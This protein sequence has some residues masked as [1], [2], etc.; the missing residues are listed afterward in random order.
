MEVESDRFAG[1]IIWQIGLRGVISDDVNR[2]TV[3]SIFVCFVERCIFDTVNHEIRI[4]CFEPAVLATVDVFVV[5]VGS[6]WNGLDGIGGIGGNRAVGGL[7]AANDAVVEVDVAAVDTVNAASNHWGSVGAIRNGTIVGAEPGWVIVVVMFDAVGATSNSAAG[8]IVDA[9]FYACTGLASRGGDDIATA[10]IKGSATRV[11]AIITDAICVAGVLHIDGSVGHVGSCA[12]YIDT[13]CVAACGG[14]GNGAAV[15]VDVICIPDASSSA[16]FAGNCNISTIKYGRI[17]AIDASNSASCA[18]LDVAAINCYAAVVNTVNWLIISIWRGLRDDF[19]TRIDKDLASVAIVAIERLNAAS[20][21]GIGITNNTN[22]AAIKIGGRGVINSAFSGGFN[23]GAAGRNCAGFKVENVAINN[24]WRI[25]EIE[26]FEFT[27]ASNGVSNRE[28]A[29]VFDWLI[30][31][32]GVT[33]E[34]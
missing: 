31:R 9:R 34:V 11:T 17:A 7:R 12:A 16:S 8:N 4:A 21:G 10:L 3:V 26:V 25:E 6:S 32:N 22:G 24:D 20:G 28:G 13:I 23:C 29:I 15:H 18:C 19:C 14:D 27:T 30:I 1:W 33:V 2:I 5:E